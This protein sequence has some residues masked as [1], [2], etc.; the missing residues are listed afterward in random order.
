M[1]PPIRRPRAGADYNPRVSQT[2]PGGVGR[3]QQAGVPPVPGSA[4]LPEA[5]ARPRLTDRLL[6]S[7]PTRLVVL[8]A[9]AGFSKTTTLRT[10]A[11]TDRRPFP[12]VSCDRRHD[13]P[14]LLMAAVV[15]ALAGVCRFDPQTA[16]A[17]ELEASWPDRAIARLGI[18]LE[19]ADEDF[20]LV[21]DDAHMLCSDG[22][23][24]ILQGLVS[25]LP[26]RAQLVIGS[27]SD[28]PLPLAR[29]RANRD[30]LELG[31]S[32]L[33]MT[34]RESQRMLRSAEIDLDKQSLRSIH[35]RTEGWP[36][37]LQLASLALAGS[38]DAAV[39]VEDF[40]GDDRAV[41]DYLQDE[42]L[43]VTDPGLVEFMTRTSILDRLSGPLC[44]AV[45]GRSDSASVLR[46]LARSNSLVFPLD[47]KDE[48]YRYHHLFAGLLR[49]ELARNEPELIGALQAS[50]ASWFDS[51]GRPDLAVEHAIASGDVCL[52]GRLIWASFPEVTGR[53]RLATINRWLD[54]VG[55]DRLSE[56]HGL[57][58]SAAHADMLAG[59]GDRAAYWL[60][61]ASVVEPSADCDVPVETDL[62]MLRT[63]LGT[64][65]VGQMGDDA[66]RVI[67]LT[68]PDS[69]WHGAA[70]F[71]RG[72]SLHLLGD[73]AAATPL[74]RNAIG[75]TALESPI[76]QALGL[77][78]MTAISWRAGDLEA[79][80]RFIGEARAQVER[81]GLAAFPAMVLVYAVE[82]LVRATT[83]QEGKAR[84][85]IATCLQLLGLLNSFPP[86]Y[87]VE[88]R[89][90]LAQTGLRLGDL[91]MTRDMLGQAQKHA[92][93]TADAVVL[94]AWMHEIEADLPVG[95]GVSDID[96]SPLTRA[97]MR[98]L[99]Y[100]PTHLTFRQIGEANHV[101]QNTVKTQARG[102]Y[103]KL[104]VGSRAEAVEAALATGLLDS[105]AEPR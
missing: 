85:G 52:A 74:L 27:R 88:T 28:P 40:A 8:C 10:W 45:L 105:S 89:L 12:W 94:G 57:L 9:P 69:A 75:L 66:G 79:A 95:N 83:G 31:V 39:A 87:E 103:R 59:A 64:E 3:S 72:V 84:S 25:V 26:R 76:M 81:C 58:F 86:W 71:Y 48:T 90:A 2:K 17:L 55:R 5:I 56:C 47:R 96:D 23:V 16:T 7:P 22:S 32:D 98:T 100:L 82:A 46:A 102:I 93:L 34:L 54:E 63:T 36:A 99:R 44:D 78:Q 38:P 14:A 24:A 41:A 49:S 65:G 68:A 67:D 43:A 91:D 92:D 70:C 80:N 6:L 13:D 101:S 42:F 60:G 77:S 1:R 30:L 11:E 4:I 33:A 51:N 35:E 18:A 53:G 73:P 61:L 21:V 29:M 15:K 19:A 20:A 97:E 37:A 50:A 104:G 62:L